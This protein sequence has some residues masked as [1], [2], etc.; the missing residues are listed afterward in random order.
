[1]RTQASTLRSP[2]APSSRRLA[3]LIL[4][5]GSITAIGPMSIDLY[6]PAFPE[7]RTSLHTSASMI[8]VSLTT[9]LIGLAV[10]QMVVGPLSDAIGRR[11]PLLVGMTGYALASVFC[12]LAPN[13]ESLLA[14]RALQGFFGSVGAVL[15]QALVRDLFDGP[16][17]ARILSRLLLVMGV[18]PVLAPTLGGQLLTVTGWRGLFWV[19]TLFG[20]VMAVVVA[21]FVRETLPAE[22]RN[23]GGVRES[24]QGYRRVLSDRLY[25]AY[26]GISVLGFFLIFGYVSG[27]PFAYQTV[28]GVS[29]QLFGVLFGANAVGMVVASQVNA[30]LVLK[31]SS[32]TILSRAVPVTVVAV[33]TLIV[34]T[35][36]GAFGLL[37]LAVP[38]FVMMTS[39]GLILPNS[40]ALALNRHPRSAGTAAAMVGMSQFVVGSLAGPAIGAFGAGTATPMVVVIAV[41]AAGMAT[42]VLLAARRAKG[43][44][45]EG[46]LEVSEPE[47]ATAG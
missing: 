25:L 37:G 11:R 43:D 27:S 18:A 31:M 41:G 19:L 36:T 35:T 4:L 16:L 23:R 13:V 14:G 22:H 7:L 46:D 44:R 24:I 28:H 9:F 17:V 42:I 3:P 21:V 15:A 45:R 10:G 30:R 26:G 33:L 47:P 29:P 8:Q 40:G 20:V 5:L 39:I 34:T 1:M 12:A 38:L 2:G 32:F 6:L